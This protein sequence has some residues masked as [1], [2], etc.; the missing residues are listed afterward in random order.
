MSM[1]GEKR[2]E[3]PQKVRK[4]A[5]ARACRDCPVE[6]VENIP[7]VPQCESCGIELKSGNIEYEHLVPDGLGGE[8]TLEN[9]GVWCRSSC[10]KKKTFKEDNPRM[11]KADRAL[12]SAFGLKPA[13]QKIQSA[14]FRRAGPQNSASRPL[15]RKSEQ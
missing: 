8:P 1:R 6:G 10:S 15:Q 12:K 2:T 9:C 7:G 11:Q 3:F 14:G 4:A 5:F 13:R